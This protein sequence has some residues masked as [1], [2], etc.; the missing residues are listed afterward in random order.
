MRRIRPVQK[1]TARW[2][3]RSYIVSKD[4]KFVNPLFKKTIPGPPSHPDLETDTE[5]ETQP[6]P[7]PKTTPYTGP[8]PQTGTDMK[9]DTATGSITEP[10]TYTG[11]ETEMN[12]DP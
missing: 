9:P 11:T 3:R 6:Y 10:S 12:T 5:S 8:A 1:L 7:V 2:C 4:D